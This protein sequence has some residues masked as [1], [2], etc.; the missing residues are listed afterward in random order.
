MSGSSKQPD[1]PDNTGQS[2]TTEKLSGTHK[3]DRHGHPP[4]RVSSC[5]A[6]SDSGSKSAAALPARK[7]K[8]EISP[9]LRIALDSMVQEGLALD[10]AARKAKMTTRGVRLALERPHVLRYL[11]QARAAFI[12]EVRATNPRRL[13]ELRAQESNPAA[14]V[15]AA[16][17]IEQLDGGDR[18][19]PPGTK[20][21]GITIVITDNGRPIKTI[22]PPSPPT[23]EARA[24]PPKRADDEG[25]DEPQW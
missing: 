11:R 21:P 16:L 7:Q 8:D 19:P 2:Q 1:K 18:T 9:Q 3:P 23:I 14:A 4:I 6:V 12:S 25:Q 5:P 13:R 24:N 10:E 15:R 17:A 22:G 20:L